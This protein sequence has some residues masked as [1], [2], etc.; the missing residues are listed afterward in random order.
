[1]FNCSCTCS[2]A[3]K[4]SI[5]A[6]EQRY[7][8]AVY[9]GNLLI[10]NKIVLPPLYSFSYNSPN[11][12]NLFNGLKRNWQKIKR[13]NVSLKTIENYFPTLQRLQQKLQQKAFLFFWLRFFHIWETNRKT[14]FHN[15]WPH[16][17]KVLLFP[18]L[19]QPN[20]SI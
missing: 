5:A 19:G 3:K 6:L 17:Q 11:Y 18:K 12:Y 14:H 20:C 1:M 4:C 15:N 9:F 13:S 16:E 10:K 7:N 8:I 2:R